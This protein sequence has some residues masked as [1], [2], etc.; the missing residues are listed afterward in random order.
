[1]KKKIAI[2]TYAS[3]WDAWR[4][5]RDRPRTLRALESRAT[6]SLLFPLA[7]TR[8]LIRR[9]PYDAALLEGPLGDWIAR[10]LV[11]EDRF[12]DGS[13]KGAIDGGAFGE[14]LRDVDFT[15][16]VSALSCSLSHSWLPVG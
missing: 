4:T 1:M 5:L 15:L 10:A 16:A 2:E 8:D 11:I 9:R 12:C 3:V 7:R 6:T 14:D 13:A